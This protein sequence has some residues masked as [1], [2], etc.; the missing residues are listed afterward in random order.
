MRT[1]LR[2][3]PLLLLSIPAFAANFTTGFVQTP[4]GEAFER[5]A[6]RDN[7]RSVR[8]PIPARYSMRGRTGAIENQ[9]N[10][11]AC[12]D[13]SLTSTL[14][15]TLKM[16][17]KDSGRLSYNYLLNC[18]SNAY[19]CYGGNFSAAQ[20]L[21]NPRGAPVYGAD[22]PYTG[23][24][25]RCENKPVAGTAARYRM[26]GAR[27]SNPSFQDIAYVLGVLR[28]PVSVVVY[29][30]ENFRNFKGAGVYKSCRSYSS[31]NHLVVLEGYD[32]ESS[33][34]K[35]GNCVF[36]QNGNLPA[37]VGRWIVRNS[38]GEIWGD[39]GYGTMKATDTAGRKCNGLANSA[40]YFDVD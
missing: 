16:A 37:G 21:V 13:F 3:L 29:S 25:G 10:C 6:P 4:E 11:G 32:C 12:W 40:L 7:F 17:G 35:Y 8:E 33:V 18:A 2:A 26:L 23:A 22:G 28:R 1:Y 14:R 30:D 34:D 38:W 31:F 9:G 36:D 19:G 5:N 24:R 20:Y 27:D 15:G 39:R